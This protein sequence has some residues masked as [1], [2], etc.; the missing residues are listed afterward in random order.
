MRLIRK[1]TQRDID[2]I[3]PGQQVDN[4]DFSQTSWDVLG[5]AVAK[6]YLDLGIA[7]DQEDWMLRR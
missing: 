1:L 6:H 3:D 4:I 5:L 2:T 7:D